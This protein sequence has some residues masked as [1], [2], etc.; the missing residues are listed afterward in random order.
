MNKGEERVVSSDVHIPRI[1]RTREEIG[2]CLCDRT[3]KSFESWWDDIMEREA[4]GEQLVTD[5]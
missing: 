4:T 2:T 5:L 1:I 3:T